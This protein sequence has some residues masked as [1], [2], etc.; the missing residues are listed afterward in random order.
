MDQTQ[1]VQDSSIT[2]HGV[3]DGACYGCGRVG[4]SRLR[5]WGG[6]VIHNDQHVTAALVQRNGASVQLTADGDLEKE[7]LRSLLLPVLTAQ[8]LAPR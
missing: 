7:G 4:S 2:I 5:G 3:W 8:G 6:W 1:A